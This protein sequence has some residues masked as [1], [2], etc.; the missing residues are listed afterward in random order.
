[1]PS[2]QLILD[3][4]YQH[5]TRI[6][7]FEEH[8]FIF[9]HLLKQTTDALTRATEGLRRAQVLLNQCHEV[10]AADGSELRTERTG[11][12]TRATPVT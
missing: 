5:A 2:Y 8:L 10:H 4:S 6:A 11:R 7:R 12:P 1:L 3:L 9:Q